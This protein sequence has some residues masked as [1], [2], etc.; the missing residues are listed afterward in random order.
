MKEVI[1]DNNFDLERTIKESKKNSKF[2]KGIE[3]KIQANYI[4]DNF[5]K[6]NLGEDYEITKEDLQKA[7]EKIVED[8]KTTTTRLDGTK[9]KKRKVVKYFVMTPMDKF[10][11]LR[12]VTEYINVNGIK[13]MTR[14]TSYLEQQDLVEEGLIYEDDVLNMSHPLVKKLI[15][16]KKR[17]KVSGDI[18]H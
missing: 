11:I 13:T 6:H 2:K 16:K 10:K 17:T 4:L 12:Q 8:T 5:A 18:E 15:P 3:K 1:F 14:T 7:K 9:T